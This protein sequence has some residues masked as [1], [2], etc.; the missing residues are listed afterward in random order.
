[1]KMRERSWIRKMLCLVLLV[2]MILPAPSVFATSDMFTSLTHLEDRL[3]VRSSDPYGQVLYGTLPSAYRSTAVTSVKDQRPYGTCSYFATI[4]SVESHAIAHKVKVGK[5]TATTSLDL[6]EI[7]LLYF[8]HHKKADSL[9][10]LKGDST[11]TTGSAATD[12]GVLVANAFQ[13]LTWAGPVKESTAPYAKIYSKLSAKKAYKSVLH[14]QGFELIPMQQMDRVKRAV[15]NSG[16]AAV[17]F[18]YNNAYFHPGNAAYCCPW[19]QDPNHAINIV[20]WDDHYSRSNFVYPPATDGAWLC[21]NQWSTGWGNKGYFWL[22][23]EE[24]SLVNSPAYTFQTK[25]ATS[26]KYNYQYD[27]GVAFD[28][29]QLRPEQ[30]SKFTA[31][32]IFTVKGAKKQKLMAVGVATFSQDIRYS[33]QI[34][35]NPKSGK[36]LSG[37]KMLKKAQT[38]TI[39]EAGFVTIPL[40]KSV[41]LKKGD[42]FTV[43]VTLKASDGPTILTDVSS[44]IGNIKS[45]TKQKKKQSYIIVSGQKLD[46]AGY[47]SG[48]TARIKAYTKK[49]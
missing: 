17:G 31:A 24:P 30:G 39:R 42:K 2:S 48:A 29:L 4:S 9:G 13:L 21:K 8:L 47:K 16:S 5:K 18:Y 46:L 37:K 28:G 12:G 35:K 1:M 20:G 45:K 33:I 41:K 44:T 7:H 27:G 26:Y 40:K 19:T 32:N 22:S 23:Y 15:M 49:Y 38:G 6:S 43:A 34:Y 36:P 10:G 11:S 14:V 3:P 25:S